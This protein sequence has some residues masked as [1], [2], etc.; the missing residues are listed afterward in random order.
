MIVSA[1]Q[2]P[3][4]YYRDRFANTKTCREVEPQLHVFSNFTSP[5]GR[6]PGC[7]RTGG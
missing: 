1:S 5:L 6:N 3:P 7:N 2:N 4:V